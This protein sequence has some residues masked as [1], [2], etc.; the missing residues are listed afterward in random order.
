VPFAIPRLACIGMF[1]ALSLL[2]PARVAAA[3]P[4]TPRLDLKPARY[5]SQVEPG[6]M[7]NVVIT[8]TNHTPRPV[9]VTFLSVDLVAGT[10]DA[11]AKPANHPLTRSAVSW[12]RF[13][14]KP[15]ELAPGEAVDVTVSIHPPRDARPGVY[16]VAIVASQTFGAL[17]ANDAQVVGSHV[18]AHVNLG[19]TFVLVVPGA[20]KAAIKLHDVQS[21]RLVWRAKTP[22]FRAT[23]EN[24]GD[25]LLKLEGE[26]Q[27]SSFGGFATRA[28]KSGEYPTLPDGRRRLEM[29]WSDRPWVG[30]FTPK[31]VAVG[32]SGSG[33]RVERTLPT[34]FVLPPWWVIALVIA[35]VILPTWS[36]RRRRAR[37]TARAIAY[38]RARQR[39]LDADLHG[40]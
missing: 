15:H 28:L 2:V 25:T 24:T 21:P 11:F 5:A 29:R 40:E 27:L 31:L 26:T 18:R 16:A 33:V 17:A 32:G 6:G 39:A 1:A 7:T 14:T 37:I 23:V 13:D 10:G 8:A 36:G 20:A 38:R 12:M 19:S 9:T 3:A 22:T 4:S 30:W 34:V 35:A